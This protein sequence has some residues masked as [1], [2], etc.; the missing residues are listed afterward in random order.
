[1]VKGRCR[2]YC[3][4]VTHS[5]QNTT[6]LLNLLI[7]VVW[8]DIVT[9][10]SQCFNAQRCFNMYTANVSMHRDAL[11]NVSMHR[12]ALTCTQPRFQHS[13]IMFQCTYD[14]SDA[15]ICTQPMHIICFNMYIASQPM[16]QHMQPQ[17]YNVQRSFKHE[18][19]NV[20]KCFSQCFNIYIRNR[21]VCFNMKAAS[22]KVLL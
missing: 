17:C 19:F 11:A 21:D 7:L 15:L 12:D 4:H 1:M 5:K 16:F 18:C 3:M 6:F 22:F 8:A 2:S 20:Q 13:I 9:I 14:N 10:H